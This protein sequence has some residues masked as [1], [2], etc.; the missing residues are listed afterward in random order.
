M[1]FRIEYE[2]KGEVELMAVNPVKEGKIEVDL[3][4]QSLGFEPALWRAG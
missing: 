3:D 1:T 4:V 2:E